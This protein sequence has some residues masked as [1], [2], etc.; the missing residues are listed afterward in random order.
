MRN[1][2]ALLSPLLI[3]ACGSETDKLSPDLRHNA[4]RA[5]EQVHARCE[6]ESLTQRRK[7]AL[8]V[9][10]AKFAKMEQQSLGTLAGIDFALAKQMN[11]YKQS[12]SNRWNCGF[13]GIPDSK[14]DFAHEK[15]WLGDAIQS[16]A[17]LA[18]TRGYSARLLKWINVPKAAEFRELAEQVYASLD[19]QCPMTDEGD[20][21]PASS[22]AR[23]AIEELGANLSGS[24]YGRH[25]EVAEADLDYLHSITSV[26]CSEPAKG[27]AGAAE[28]AKVE[29]AL[30][31][32]IREL[33]S[34]TKS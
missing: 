14:L 17:K 16:T 8:T 24:S 12:Q 26:E 6:R 32:A 9:L 21:F 25:L 4:E 2:L 30:L 3:A 27:R 10:S 34:L 20:S 13:Y 33:E 29:A 22:P 28:V 7:Q 15:R 18:G 23:R 31:K 1:A 11:N 19:P 5:Y